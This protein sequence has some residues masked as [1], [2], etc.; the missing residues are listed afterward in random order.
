MGMPCKCPLCGCPCHILPPPPPRLQTATKVLVWWCNEVIISRWTTSKRLR[1]FRQLR[2]VV[3]CKKVVG[4]ALHWQCHCFQIN[5]STYLDN[6]AFNFCLVWPWAST[7]M[8]Q[9]CNKNCWTHSLKTLLDRWNE[10]PSYHQDLCLHY[11]VNSLQQHPQGVFSR[12][13]SQSAAWHTI[14]VYSRMCRKLFTCEPPAARNVCCFYWKKSWVCELL[15]LK[16]HYCPWCLQ[17]FIIPPCLCNWIAY[18]CTL[19]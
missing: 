5:R 6:V 11:H 16:W 8:L 1:C 17:S 9:E 18:V 14:Q 12:P 7:Q 2:C 3:W 15:S 19:A 10:H 4:G 13:E